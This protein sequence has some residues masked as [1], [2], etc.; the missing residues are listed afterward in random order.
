M[1]AM[2]DKASWRETNFHHTSIS[3][4]NLKQSAEYDVDPFLTASSLGESNIMM[5]FGLDWVKQFPM[6]HLLLLDY[7]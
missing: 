6:L 1:H 2:I 4:S 7:T 3:R 5:N